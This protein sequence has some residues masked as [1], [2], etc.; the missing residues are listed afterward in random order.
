[1][2]LHMR[3]SLTTAADIDALVDEAL[4]SVPSR[5]VYRDGLKRVFD[6]A[7]V[8]LVSLPVLTLTMIFAA[9]VAL[10]GKSP[11]YVQKR[12]GRNGRAFSM[13]KLRSMVTDAD[14]QLALHLESDPEARAEWDHSQK[15]RHDPRITR[16]GRLIR[17]TSI[18]EFPQFWNVLRGDMSLVGP[19][20]MMVSQQQ[21]Y[22]GTAY[23]A[24]RP[25]VTGFWQI[26]VRNESSFSERAKF[27]ADYLR[28]LSLGTDLRVMLKTIRVVLRGTGC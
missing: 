23:Y 20:P 1:M 12:V 11:F 26:S 21:M 28:Q 16:V 6:V 27:D 22:P 24:L 25:G 19:R 15:L 17:K 4:A 18:D 10:D 9:L 13:V 14:R 7:V 3:Q 8:L 5:N 2:T